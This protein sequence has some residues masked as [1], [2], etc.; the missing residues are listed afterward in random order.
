MIPND[1]TPYV[2]SVQE[3]YFCERRQGPCL[4]NHTLF[5]THHTMLQLSISFTDNNAQ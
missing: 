2:C 4:Q 5:V 3:H 1:L